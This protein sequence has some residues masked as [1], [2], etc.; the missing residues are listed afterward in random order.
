M[1]KLSSRE[2]IFAVLHNHSVK[3]AL[4]FVPYRK[5]DTVFFRFV[6]NFELLF[7]KA[8]LFFLL[9]VHDSA[10]CR[11]TE[12]R[13][14][15][16]PPV[17]PGSLAYRY[18]QGAVLPCRHRDIAV[19]T[20]IELNVRDLSTHPVAAAVFAESLLGKSTYLRQLFPDS[21]FGFITAARISEEIAAVSENSVP[22]TELQ[23]LILRTV[24]VCNYV[25]PQ[26]FSTQPVKLPAV[27]DKACKT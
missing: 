15:Y 24:R 7:I 9:V 22:D 13:K 21:E 3:P 2:S 12:R 19:S 23:P 17:M 20:L 14:E 25:Q 18:P 1:Q 5:S 16:A 6:K 27:S 4:H 8:L 11:Y 10:G 26:D